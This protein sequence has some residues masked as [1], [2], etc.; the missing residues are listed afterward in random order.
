MRAPWALSLQKPGRL[1]LAFF[2][3]VHFIHGLTEDLII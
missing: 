1:V 3:F 2:V